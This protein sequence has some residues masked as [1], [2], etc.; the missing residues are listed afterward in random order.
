MLSPTRL[1]AL[2]VAA[3]LLAAQS[4]WAQDRAKSAAEKQTGLRVGEKA[5]KFALKDQAG[6][7]RSLDEFLQKGKL[8]LVFYRSA[9]W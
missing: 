6:R 3:I 5:P 1:T 2:A 8:A 7:E 9:D 4:A